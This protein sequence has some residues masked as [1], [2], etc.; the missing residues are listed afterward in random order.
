MDPDLTE[1]MKPSLSLKD[2]L[3]SIREGVKPFIVGERTD[4]SL[5]PAVLRH[6]IVTLYDE[7]GGDEILMDLT[8]IGYNTLRAWH[9]SYKR[10]P[11]YFLKPRKVKKS[12]DLSRKKIVSA[13]LGTTD[14][15]D[16]Y[17]DK[18][19]MPSS[20]TV[21]RADFKNESSTEEIRSTLPADLIAKIDTV[22]RQME[23]NGDRSSAGFKTEVA[24]LVLKAGNPRQVAI[25]LELNEKLVAGWRD[26]FI[27]GATGD[28][29]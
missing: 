21:K 7:H 5:I 27:Q 8:K 25:L 29:K 23:T 12:H 1:P 17:A 28:E 3:R 16:S 24:K 10:D 4:A 14:A 26:A 15:A 22:K 20:F 9:A 18:E 2:R 6:E 13:V 11:L 19:L